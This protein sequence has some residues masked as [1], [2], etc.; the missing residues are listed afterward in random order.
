MLRAIAGFEPVRAGGSARGRRAREPR[1]R[2]AG[3]RTP[4]RDDVSGLRA[5]SA[6]IGA[7]N[8]DSGCAARRR[9]RAARAPRRC[10]SSSAWPTAANAYPHELSGGQQQRIALARALAPSPE[11]LLLDEPFSISTST[12]ASGSRSKCATS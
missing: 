7:A 3:P 9:R 10:S 6:S 5:V 12:P 1:R 4:R 11:L 8:V 2:R